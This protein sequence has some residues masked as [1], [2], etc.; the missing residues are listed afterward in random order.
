MLL[1]VRLLQ[2]WTHN[3][4]F[5]TVFCSVLDLPY[6]ALNATFDGELRPGP[7]FHAPQH[8]YYEYDSTAI[9]EDF[10]PAGRGF[11]GLTDLPSLSGE[12]VSHRPN[13]NDYQTPYYCLRYNTTSQIKRLNFSNWRDQLDFEMPLHLLSNLTRLDTIYIPGPSNRSAYSVS[14]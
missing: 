2:L 13:R 11:L 12:F 6:D 9:D 7:D 5:S 14:P 1:F 3:L 4:N 10:I 8:N